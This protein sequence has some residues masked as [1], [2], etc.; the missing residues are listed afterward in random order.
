MDMQQEEFHL[1]LQGLI[2]KVTQIIKTGQENNNVSQ[3]LG[4]GNNFPASSV[5]SLIT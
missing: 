3:V 4:Q 1:L 5:S 2:K